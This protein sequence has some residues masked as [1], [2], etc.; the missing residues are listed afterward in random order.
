MEKELRD[1]NAMVTTVW[2][3]VVFETVSQLA[4]SRFF[5]RQSQQR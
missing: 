2:N 1:T 5:I 3:A 4:S